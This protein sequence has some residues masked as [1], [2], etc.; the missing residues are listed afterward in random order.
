MHTYF[1]I[2]RAELQIGVLI[3]HGRNVRKA[4][5]TLI[6]WEYGRRQ[7]FEGTQINYTLS[8]LIRGVELKILCLGVEIDLYVRR[9][10]FVEIEILFY[11]LHFT[12]LCLP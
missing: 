11:M 1:G 7:N 9:L 12:M 4:R 5:T 3:K 10:H 2:F 6:V 8:V